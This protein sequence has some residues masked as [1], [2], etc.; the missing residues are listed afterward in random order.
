[1][2]NV[3]K[4]GIYE[5]GMFSHTGNLP[6]ELEN[7]RRKIDEDAQAEAP[8]YGLGPLTFIEEKISDPIVTMPPT[9]VVILRRYRGAIVDYEKARSRSNSAR[10]KSPLKM[11]EDA[12]P[13]S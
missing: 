5:R 3:T 12:P 4:Y 13:T 6:H 2:E 1:M 9:Y 7:F 8:L 11:I 10:R